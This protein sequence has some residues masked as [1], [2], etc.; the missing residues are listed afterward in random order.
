MK[1]QLDINT[2][3]KHEIIS[4]TPSSE[5]ATER[6]ASSK[7]LRQNWLTSS[8]INRFAA[9]ST[10]TIKP[11]I[12]EKKHVEQPQTLAKRIRNIIRSK[13]LEVGPS[14]KVVSETPVL[15]LDS[16]ARPSRAQEMERASKQPDRRCVSKKFGA[17]AEKYVICDEVESNETGDVVPEY[18]PADDGKTVDTKDIDMGKR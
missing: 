2:R 18:G 1:V 6:E 13:A 15:E 14:F 11:D 8:F 10:K 16:I 7:T 17:N 3:G 4:K 12:Q 5:K 9:S